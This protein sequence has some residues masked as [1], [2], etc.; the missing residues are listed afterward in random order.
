MVLRDPFSTPETI[1][2]ETPA[3]LATSRLVGEDGVF[4]T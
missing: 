1:E 3:R 2:R 4:N